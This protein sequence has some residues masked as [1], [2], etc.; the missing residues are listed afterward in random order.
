GVDRDSRKLAEGFDERDE[1]VLRSLEKA[2]KTTHEM[3]VT[4]SICGEAPSVYP[5]LTTKLVEWGIT[6]VSVNPDM[7]EHT[8]A[9]IA[10]AE[11]GLAGRPSYLRRLVRTI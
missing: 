1:A 7:I 2:I 10:I 5:E 11:E 6:S 4:S 3:E 9:I 8:R